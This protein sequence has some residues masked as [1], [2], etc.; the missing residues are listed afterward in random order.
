MVVP[1]SLFE[2]L[3]ERLRERRP[4]IAPDDTSEV[5]SRY[6]QDGGTGNRDLERW[7]RS[8][9]STDAPW[10]DSKIRRLSQAPFVGR[11]QG[12]I[13]GRQSTNARPERTSREVDANSDYFT[14]STD[15]LDQTYTGTPV[16]QC[17]PVPFSVQTLPF[18]FRRSLFPGQ[19]GPM[20]LPAIPRPRTP[21]WPNPLSEILRGY[22]RVAPAYGEGDPD[23]K[24]EIREAREICRDASEAE[25][26]GNFGAGPNKNPR[27]DPWDVE[28][29]VRG[30]VSERCGGNRYDRPDGKP[31]KRKYL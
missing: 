29:C 5:A 9:P 26:K 8:A 22:A 3:V 23:C 4:D 30:R 1:R 27:G 15:T 24:E 6:P 2:L 17:L 12:K 28:D 10:Q 16:P 20:C 11:V 19:V 25:W 18:G 21:E 31:K 7:T 14:G 13:D